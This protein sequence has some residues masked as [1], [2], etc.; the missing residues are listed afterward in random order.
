MN[1][2]E[3]AVGDYLEWESRIYEVVGD[4]LGQR[5]IIIKSLDEDVCKH[6][7]L[8]IGY[9]YIHIVPDSPL[10]IENAKPIKT[11]KSKYEKK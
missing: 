9:K 1:K 7:K 10:Y 6:C 5:T 8:P 4:D 11:L 3:V 2:Y